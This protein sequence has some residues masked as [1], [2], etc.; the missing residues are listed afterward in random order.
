MR[1]TKILTALALGLALCGAFAMSAQ[2]TLYTLDFI[3]TPPTA[4]TIKYL[5]GN[6]P[7]TGT[8]IEVDN[9]YGNNTPSHSGVTLALSN[10]VLDFTTGNFSSSTSGEYVFNGGGSLTIYGG[11]PTLG[12]AD[13]TL[14][15]IGVFT[16][17][18]DVDVGVGGGTFTA[19]FNDNKN[20]TLVNYY[21]ITSII[22]TGGNVN[23][24]FATASNLVPP[25]AFES[26]SVL[27][28]DVTNVVPLPP[29][30]LLLGSGL[31]GLLAFRW[32][33]H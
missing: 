33:K 32:R 7:L 21:G 31:L 8:T 1:L 13:G 2:A 9:V 10:A 24:S 18:P 17:S 30:A 15:A 12:I 14:L 16:D 6:N 29:S 4:G 23:L 19:T 3:I 11:I 27:S 28:G 5:G 20:S 25:N 22:F 26:S